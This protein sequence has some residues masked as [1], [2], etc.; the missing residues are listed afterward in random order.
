MGFFINLQYKKVLCKYIFTR[1]LSIIFLKEEI[2]NM[3]D[4]ISYAS[5]LDLV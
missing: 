4:S 5:A 1:I 3:C 2:N